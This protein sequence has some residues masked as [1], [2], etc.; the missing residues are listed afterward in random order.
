MFNLSDSRGVAP[1]V[2][3]RLAKYGF[4]YRARTIPELA[5]LINIDPNLLMR[6]IT[7]FNNLAAGNGRCPFGRDFSVMPGGEI[8]LNAEWFYASPRVPTVHHTMGG[9][10]I[11]TLTRV[12]DT[13]GNIIPG[14]YAAGEVV[15]GVHG[16]N[17]LGGNAI[18]E[19]FVFGRIAGDSV[20]RRR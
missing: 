11:D 8:D 1:A 7:D 6:T 17:R 14:F 10:D 19:A 12:R 4:V 15:G 5:R 16:A 20:A 2:G 9:V 13:R 3:D 18:T